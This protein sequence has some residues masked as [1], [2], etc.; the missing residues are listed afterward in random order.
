MNGAETRKSQQTDKFKF[1]LGIN[2]VYK[3]VQ[4]EQLISWKS[5]GGRFID[6]PR[7]IFPNGIIIW[8]ALFQHPDGRMQNGRE[9][10]TGSWGTSCPPLTFQNSASH[11]R[12]RFEYPSGADRCSL[13]WYV[14][15]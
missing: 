8:L 4:V 13:Q 6:I 12:A 7:R 10:C 11:S 1:R 2:C 3:C 14:D 9:R 15:K 5:R